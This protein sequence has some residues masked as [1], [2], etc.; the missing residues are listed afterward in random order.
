LNSLAGKVMGC[1]L[2]GQGTGDQF[3]AGVRNF[4]LLHSIQTGFGAHTASCPTVFQALSFKVKQPGHEAYHSIPFSAKV[5]NVWNYT[6]NLPYNFIP[7][8]YILIK[9]FKY[10]EIKMPSFQSHVGN[11]TVT[12][13][14]FCMV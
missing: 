14:L 8:V 6:S 13:Q 9:H 12:E 3:P 11:G 7:V 4:S 1:G 10:I 5:K 2:D